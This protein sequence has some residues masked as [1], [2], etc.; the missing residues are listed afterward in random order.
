MQNIFTF[1]LPSGE[2]IAVMILC[3]QGELNIEK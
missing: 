1:F 2:I 3:M